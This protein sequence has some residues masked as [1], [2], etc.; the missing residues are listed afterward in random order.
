MP[1][2]QCASCE[3]AFHVKPFWIKKGYGKYCSL[4][5]KYKGSRTGKEVACF[6]CGKVSYK[7]GKDLQRSKSET[8]FCSKSCQTT[9]RNQEFIGS[10]HANWTG[11]EYSY[12]SVLPR[13]GIEKVCTLCKTTDSRVMAVHHIDKNRKNNVVSNLAWLCHNCHHLVHHHKEEAKKFVKSLLELK[14]RT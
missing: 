2:V 5:C 9:W 7:S 14:R 8:Y 12:R 1:N 13:S 6:L 11:G 10:K 3:K 4:E